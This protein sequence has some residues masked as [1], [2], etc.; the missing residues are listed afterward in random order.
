MPSYA[1]SDPP[2][3]RTWPTSDSYIKL[4]DA[5]EPWAWFFPET[6]SSFVI[7]AEPPQRPLLSRADV[8][9]A[10]LQADG[11]LEASGTHCALALTT[12]FAMHSKS[13]AASLRSLLTSL[14][15]HLPNA[16]G[17]C[18]D[19]PGYTCGRVSKAACLEGRQERQNVCNPQRA[20]DRR[21]AGAMVERDPIRRCGSGRAEALGR[22]SDRARRQS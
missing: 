2:G 21:R 1:V 8:Y 3:Q 13:F 17:Y 4:V 18:I 7:W 16:W 5:P 10:L 11:Y 12:P 19:M 20:R 14:A 22:R 6:R 9:A 15:D